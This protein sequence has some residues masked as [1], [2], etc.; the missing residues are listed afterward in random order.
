MN[1]VIICEGGPTLGMGH[2]VRMQRLA[3]TRKQHLINVR[4]LYNNYSRAES[5]LIRIIGK[6]IAYIN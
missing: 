2:I 3:S 5:L 1:Y 6:D 4:E